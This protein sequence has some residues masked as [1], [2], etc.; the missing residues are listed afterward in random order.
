[1]G[2][3]GEKS[4]KAFFYCYDNFFNTKII[5]IILEHDTKPFGPLC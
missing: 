2:H 5:T 3:G 4:L 1:M